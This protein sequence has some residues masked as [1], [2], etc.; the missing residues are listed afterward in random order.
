[1][2]FRHLSNN[3]QISNIFLEQRLASYPAELP[4]IDFAAYKKQLK[5]PAVI[6][7]LEKGVILIYIYS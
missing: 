5:N 7:A 3:Y 2:S 6:D 4:K 1:M